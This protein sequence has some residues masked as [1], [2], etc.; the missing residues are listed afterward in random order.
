VLHLKVLTRARILISLPIPRSSGDLTK[1]RAHVPDC[2]GRTFLSANMTDQVAI[3]LEDAGAVS[4]LPER[5]TRAAACYV[6]AHGAGAGMT[7]PF[8]NACAEA[9][10]QHDLA[11]LRFQF[12]FLERGS[13][14][15]DSPAVAQSTVRAA[16]K[17]AAGLV[18]ICR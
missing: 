3:P 5:P 13:R 1:A 8:L 16:V 9:L 11:T 18:P 15:P 6:L 10:A 7:H 17:A 12:P 4:G 14:R 2:T